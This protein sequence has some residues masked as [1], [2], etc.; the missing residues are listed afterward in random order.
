M[1][2]Y[3]VEID[4]RKSH[5]KQIHAGDFIRKSHGN[6]YDRILHSRDFDQESYGKP[7]CSHSHAERRIIQIIT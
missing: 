2:L 4:D 7:V 3:K 5:G 1:R 6:H